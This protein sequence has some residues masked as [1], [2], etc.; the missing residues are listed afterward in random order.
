[1][2]GL[3]TFQV[4]GN[5]NLKP[6]KLG[7]SGNPLGRPIG[8]KNGLKARITRPLDKEASPDILKTLKAE[9][10][11]LED[12]DNAKVI[13]Y[14]LCREAQKGNL[15]TIKLV[16]EYADEGGNNP[17]DKIFHTVVNINSVKDGKLERKV[18][19]NGQPLER[20]ED[21]V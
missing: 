1:L 3:L 17:L 2:T 7:Q 6:F 15:Q 18:L 10:V 21:G 8:A 12:R 19:V 9:G 14:V 5:G 13:A 11:E 20:G 16:A 4:L